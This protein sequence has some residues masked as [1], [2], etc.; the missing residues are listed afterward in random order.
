VDTV[1]T[2][3]SS[4]QFYCSA[5]PLSLTITTYTLPLNTRTVWCKRCQQCDWLLA[6]RNTGERLPDRHGSASMFFFSSIRL[7]YS[8]TWHCV[9]GWWCSTF[10]NTMVASSSSVEMEVTLPRC[11]ETSYTY[12]LLM[13]HHKPRKGAYLRHGFPSSARCSHRLHQISY[14]HISTALSPMGN[15]PRVKLTIP[16]SRGI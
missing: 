10:Q 5:Q 12:H 8:G 16:Y 15:T 4:L 6:A 7:R 9:T 3:E 13:L 14:L 11:F 2:S 1:D